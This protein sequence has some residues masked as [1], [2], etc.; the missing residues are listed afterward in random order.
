MRIDHAVIL[1]KD[2]AAATSNYTGLG[3]T[4]SPGGEHI[5][6]ATHNALI[7][8]EDGSY[9]ELLAFLRSAPDH[10]WWRHTLQGE[11]LIDYALLPAHIG[12]DIE[13][14]A[15]R[16]LVLDGPIAGGR[17]RPDGQEIGWQTGQASTA[18]LPFLC[19][20]VTPRGWRVPFGPAARHPNGIKGIQAVLVSVTN[21]ELS[22]QRYTAL[23]GLEPEIEEG[24][25]LF[26]LPGSQII[27]SN[28]RPDKVFKNG[29]AQIQL[30]SVL[31]NISFDPKLTHNVS[32]IISSI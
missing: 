7:A 4:V 5:D 14:A 1:V 18:D 8:F 10:K 29:P 9:L 22:R 28:N 26:N 21:L 3:F 13:A 17:I 11:G 12:A 19:A 27:L 2:L 30:Q 15:A 23:L 20:D 31:P 6:G 25:C 24:A 32:Y 16:G